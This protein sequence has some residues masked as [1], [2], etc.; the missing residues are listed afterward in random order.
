VRNKKTVLHSNAKAWSKFLS[1]ND[2]N[3]FCTFTTG[4]SLSLKSARRLMI[5]FYNRIQSK[6]FNNSKEV[7]LYWVAEE[8]ECRDSY[9]LHGLIKHPSI[10]GYNVIDGLNNSYQIVSG[11]KKKKTNYRIDLD[12]YDKTLFGAK[13]LTKTQRLD[14]HDFD[15]FFGNDI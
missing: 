12:K 3:L 5:R 11:A 1:E 15:I 4:Y 7:V 9:H 2:W 14:G 10:E 13:Y 8:N 6:I